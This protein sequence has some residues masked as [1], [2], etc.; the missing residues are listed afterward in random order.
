MFCLSF[1]PG[2]SSKS[3]SLGAISMVLV[4]FWE[5]MYIFFCVCQGTCTFGVYVLL[6]I[7]SR[8]SR[9]FFP[10]PSVQYSGEDLV[11]GL[12]ACFPLWGWCLGLE[13]SP[14]VP[15]AWS[16]ASAET[17]QFPGPRHHPL[18]YSGFL[19][20]PATST[21]I[22]ATPCMP[23]VTNSHFLLGL[24]CFWQ[25]QPRFFSWHILGPR[26]FPLEVISV[27]IHSPMEELM[28]HFPT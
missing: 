25:M 11:N 6:F 28:Q 17:V 5:D 21:A 20:G 2:S 8:N 4:I 9:F 15:P 19:S 23:L 7:F 10:Q 3:F 18:D 27:Q 1:F 16:V 14:S 13:T 22:S 26:H 12:R 24:R